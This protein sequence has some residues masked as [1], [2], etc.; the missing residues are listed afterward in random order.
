MML[1]FAN[2][3]KEWT[4]G[5]LY[6]VKLWFANKKYAGQLRVLFPGRSQNDQLNNSV[7][8][9][10]LEKSWTYCNDDNAWLL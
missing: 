5:P 1:S 10:L 8:G 2:P 7:K 4:F 9:K 3:P 6:C